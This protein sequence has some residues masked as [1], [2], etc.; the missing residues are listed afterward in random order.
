MLY[1]LYAS[2]LGALGQSVR[3]DLI[4]NNLANVNTPAFR[5]D[6]IAFRER[7][8]EALEDRPDLKY[9]NGLVHRYG[10]APF[11]D[12]IAYDK[13]A[14]A[15]D[16]TN[17]PLDFSIQGSGYFVVRDRNTERQYYTRAGNFQFDPGGNL[18]TAD[19]RYLVLSEDGD[20]IRIDVETGVDIKLDSNGNLFQGNE[21]LSRF[22][23][24][25]FADPEGIRKFGENLYE[26]FAAEPQRTEEYKLVQAVLE[27][28]SVNAVAE[29]VDLIRTVRSI[30][31]NLQMVKIQDS[32]LDRLVNEMGRPAR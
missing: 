2:G 18:T 7:L 14:G 5:R 30:E 9:Y 19:G 15:F 11:I 24:V 4:A 17:R 27:S 29:M 31:S 16:V 10:G 13:H 23:I 26:T 25:D 6:Q 28:S 22:Q 3:M 20:P 21:F 32:T 8:A 1:G 12:T